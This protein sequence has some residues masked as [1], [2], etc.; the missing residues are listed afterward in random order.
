[1]CTRCAHAIKNLSKLLHHLLTR[2]SPPTQHKS[3]FL[4]VLHSCLQACFT[5]TTPCALTIALAVSTYAIRLAVELIFFYI[6]T[7]HTML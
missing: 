3:T 1:M 7:S 5:R 4:L 6:L 2:P